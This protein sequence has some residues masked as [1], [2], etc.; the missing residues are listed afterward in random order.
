MDRITLDLSVLTVTTF[1]E[2]TIPQ[3]TRLVADLSVTQALESQML[4]LLSFRDKRDR[5][6]KRT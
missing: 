6:W 2:I 3:I 1:P 5:L 4:S